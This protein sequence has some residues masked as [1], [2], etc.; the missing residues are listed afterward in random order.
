VFSRLNRVFAS[1][2]IA[3]GVVGLSVLPAAAATAAVTTTHPA[4][5]TRQSPSLTLTTNAKD[6]AYKGKVTV[7]AHLGTTC[8]NRDVTIYEEPF[9]SKD[10]KIL[11]SGKVNSKGNLTA[12]YEPMTSTTFIAHFGGDADYA[13]KTV[14]HDAYVAADV[15]L[16][17]TGYYTTAN[18]GGT[19]YHV[20]HH[21][22][23]LSPTVTVAPNKHGECV[24]LEIDARH[25]STWYLVYATGC[26]TLNSASKAVAGSLQLTNAADGLYR[27]HALYVRS[28]KDTKNLSANSPWFYF[29]I[30]K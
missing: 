4:T 26:G 15:S 11:V 20:F 2:C 16:Q 22:G 3:V 30:V 12:T 13:P 19:I 8:T 6:Y 14:T 10:K 5:K 18:H 21:T 23:K 28:S 17:V 29:S 24:R 27:I 1:S 7:T 9:G 25:D